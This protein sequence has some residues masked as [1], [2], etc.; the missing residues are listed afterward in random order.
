MS[1]LASAVDLIIE[2]QQR[3]LIVGDV[4][5][6]ERLALLA[7]AVE[8]EA[9]YARNVERGFPIVR[10]RRGLSFA[11]LLRTP[12]IRAIRRSRGLSL[13]DDEQRE[14]AA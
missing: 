8:H 1:A 14:V 6:A 10:R 11:E 2:G 12:H 7:R 3:A 13:P 5:Q 9:E 4:D